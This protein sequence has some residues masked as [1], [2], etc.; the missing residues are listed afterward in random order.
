[1]TWKE[2]FTPKVAVNCAL[3]D[4]QGRILLVKRKDNNLWCMP[5]GLVD[6]GEQVE[7]TAI[8]EVKEEA[9]L[10]VEIERLTGVYSHPNDSLYIDRGSQYQMVI[11]TF[12]GRII[13]GT[14]E[15]NSETYGF[16]FF[17][18]NNL[19]LLVETHRQRITDVLTGQPAAFIR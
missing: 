6:L 2:L 14:F 4:E 9:G 3:F 19:P 5:G 10:T 15:E 1:M 11:L 17:E 7:Q 13:E 12:L 16:D 18:V 8:R